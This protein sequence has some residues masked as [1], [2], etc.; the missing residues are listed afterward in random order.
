MRART[1]LVVACF[2]LT[3]DQV[4]GEARGEHPDP[5]L[6]APAPVA[7]REAGTRQQVPGPTEAPER[8]SKPRDLVATEALPGALSHDGYVQ[9]RRDTWQANKRINA[10]LTA[11]LRTRSAEVSKLRRELETTK[12]KLSVCEGRTSV[13][14]DGQ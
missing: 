13:G 11:A 2:L 4:L 3:T 1:L 9:I 14:T 8:P 12:S 5:A 7:R 10:D 6:P